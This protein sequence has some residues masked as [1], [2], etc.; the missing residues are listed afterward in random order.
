MYSGV[1]AHDTFLL[2]RVQA[3]RGI[4]TYSRRSQAVCASTGS[5]SVP[6][7]MSCRLKNG[8]PKGMYAT[9]VQEDTKPLWLVHA[10]H[11]GVPES[12]RDHLRDASKAGRGGQILN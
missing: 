9:P 11:Q 8:E 4:A 1:A 5:S 12:R 7:V 3:A 2:R 10:H 6:G